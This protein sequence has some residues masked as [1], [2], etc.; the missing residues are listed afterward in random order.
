MAARD[1]FPAL[2]AAMGIHPL[3]D[4]RLQV[5]VPGN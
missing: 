2:A 3:A 4:C 5:T 1:V